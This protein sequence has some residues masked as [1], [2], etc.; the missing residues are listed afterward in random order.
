MKH[1]LIL[2]TFLASFS[3]CALNEANRDK[4][5]RNLCSLQSTINLAVGVSHTAVRTEFRVFSLEDKFAGF[6]QTFWRTAAISLLDWVSSMSADTLGAAR[7][8]Q[9]MQKVSPDILLSAW[10]F[11][12]KNYRQPELLPPGPFSYFEKDPN[13]AELRLM[14]LSKFKPD[15]FS[16]NKAPKGAKFFYRQ[17][18]KKILDEASLW[19]DP[20]VKDAAARYLLN[21]S[22]QSI[23]LEYNSLT[24]SGNEPLNHR[25]IALEMLRG[26]S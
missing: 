24:K 8:R 17:E 26:N 13:P 16:Y 15:N 6:Y 5:L 25:A 19:S 7:F 14:I 23:L 2:I 9:E 21:E 11:A 12:I 18:L 10:S 20:E 3:L 4:T 1:G 22:G